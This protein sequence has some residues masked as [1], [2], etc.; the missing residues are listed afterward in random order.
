MDE[1]LSDFV[2]GVFVGSRS[3]QHGYFGCG[4]QPL[5]NLGLQIHRH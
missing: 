1:S 3:P 2:R 4:N 5:L